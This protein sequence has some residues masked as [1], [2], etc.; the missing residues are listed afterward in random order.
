MLVPVIFIVKVSVQRPV[1][2]HCWDHHNSLLA[3]VT[4]AHF[5]S[6]DPLCGTYK[7]WC[8]FSVCCYSSYLGGS[9]TYSLFRVAAPLHK[10]TLGIYS[11]SLQKWQPLLSPF[12]FYLSSGEFPLTRIWYLAELRLLS[13]DFLSLMS[14]S[15][16][17]NVIKQA[18]WAD[19]PSR[20]KFTLFTLFQS[21]FG[22]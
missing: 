22:I 13:V 9:Y 16:T 7:I 20:V 19:I 14:N 17:T 12:L 3:G 11:S 18:S 5:G 15:M 6:Q 4:T 2:S 10:C 8:G 1:V 21:D